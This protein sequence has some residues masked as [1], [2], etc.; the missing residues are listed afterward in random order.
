MTLSSFREKI[1]TPVLLALFLTAQ[2]C[3]CQWLHFSTAADAPRF[4]D[5]TIAACEVEN[6]DEHGETPHMLHSVKPKLLL[7]VSFEIAM[8]P[9]ISKN[10]EV[11][12]V[13]SLEKNSDIPYT[14]QTPH[15]RQERIL[16]CFRS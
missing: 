5:F 15:R 9:V 13:Q 8:A 11:P 3:F 10:V 12:H 16:S 2:L 4:A 1:G 6:T 7:P 14:F